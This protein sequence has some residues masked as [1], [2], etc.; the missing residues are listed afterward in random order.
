MPWTGEWPGKAECREFG[1][2]SKLVIGV[3]WVPCDKDEP[4]ASENLNRLYDDCYWDKEAQRFYK[5]I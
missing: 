3:G 5:I 4:G 1:L 2:Y